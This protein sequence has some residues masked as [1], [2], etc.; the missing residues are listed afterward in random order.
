MINSV[1]KTAAIVRLSNHVINMVNSTVGG[2]MYGGIPI[3]DEDGETA[4]YTLSV[5]NDGVGSRCLMFTRS[6]SGASVD[7][8]LRPVIYIPSVVQDAGGTG[9][10]CIPLYECISPSI[11][12]LVSGNYQLTWWTNFSESPSV[13]ELGNYIF[14]YWK[15]VKFKTA[16]L[17]DIEDNDNAC[18]VLCTAPLHWE[19]LRMDG[20]D[21]RSYYTPII[22]NVAVL[23]CIANEGYIVDFSTGGGGGGGTG[24]GNRIH[25][26]LSTKECGF[27]GAVFMPS[28]MP[29]IM[30]WK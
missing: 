20:Y 2:E 6:L 29:R 8:I 7:S 28:A 17:G 11:A 12:T 1:G 19:K 10:T 15:I 21:A 3:Y 27:A 18:K 13:D 9:V 23:A 14:E 5:D 22:R 24:S 26:H 16:S 4:R 30:S 25:N